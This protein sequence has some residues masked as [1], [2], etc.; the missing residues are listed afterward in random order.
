M[1]RKKTIYN[2]SGDGEKPSGYIVAETPE[3]HHP[4][5]LTYS[6]RIS[7]V[8]LSQ[9]LLINFMKT[10]RT[11]EA[12]SEL[13]TVTNKIEIKKEAQRQLLFSLN[14]YRVLKNLKSSP[15]CLSI[16]RDNKEGQCLFCFNIP[17]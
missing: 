2:F 13:E 14:T 16:Y 10:K 11:K 6:W 15:D 3:P 8:G 7:L 12:R 4:A 9:I 5:Y 17:A 1:C